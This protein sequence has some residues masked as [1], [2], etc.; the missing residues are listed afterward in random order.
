VPRPH[1]HNI[2]PYGID[3]TE[4]MYINEAFNA[5]LAKSALK[6]GDVVIV[7]TGTPGVAAVVPGSLPRAN[8]AD[9][10]IVRP[11]P[12]LDPRF[13]AYYVNGAA[14]GHID[15]YVVGAV[16]QHYNIGSAKRLRV[17]L[18]SIEEQRAI[19]SVLGALDD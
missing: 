11:G 10:V 15:A 7:R 18:P 3:T 2:R 13:L 14:Q 4:L 12:R 19:G 17:V 1:C 8:C 5:R 16:Q 6:A 9:L